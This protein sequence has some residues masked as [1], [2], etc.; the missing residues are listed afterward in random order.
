MNNLFNNMLSYETI[1]AI[2]GMIFFLVLVFALVWSV[3]KKRNITK[4]LPFFI[5]PIIM[6]AYP[7]LKSIKIGDFILDIQAQSKIVENNPRDTAAVKRLEESLEKLKTN[8]R[9]SNNSNVLV[10]AANAQ[11]IP[12]IIILLLSI[13]IWHGR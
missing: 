6:V 1:L 4:L 13:L 11:M 3:L 9:L 5:I 12:A 8:D 2:M 7:T 10:A